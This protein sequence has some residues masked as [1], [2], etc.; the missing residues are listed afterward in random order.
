MVPWL[1]AVALVAFA[2][3]IAEVRSPGALRGMGPWVPAVVGGLAASGLTLLLLSAVSIAPD[4]C[5]SPG[6]VRWDPNGGVE[7]WPHANLEMTV[8]PCETLMVA[9]QTMSTSTDNPEMPCDPTVASV[10]VAVWHPTERAVT[11]NLTDLAPGNTWVGVTWSA[12]N[13]AID[14]KIRDVSRGW[15]SA[16]NCGGGCATVKV[17]L[18]SDGNVELGSDI[19]VRPSFQP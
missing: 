13:E 16:A 19:R 8:H 15:F 2:A 3:L 1:G 7:H 9:S 10:C 14:D 4:G 11:V 17:Y 5:A 18:F 6:S 12:A